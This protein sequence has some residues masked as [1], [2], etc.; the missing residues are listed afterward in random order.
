MVGDNENNGKNGHDENQGKA[1][2]PC[3]GS[4]DSHNSQSLILPPRGDYQTLLS[5]RKSEL[6]Y[7]LTYRF[8]QRFLRRGDRTI[9]QM[10]QAAR[11]GKQNIVEGSKA[12]TT[13]KEMEIKLTNVARASLEELLEDYRDFLKVRD[14]RIWDK[15]STEARYVRKL[16]QGEGVCYDTFREFVDTRP[17]EVVANIAICLVHQANYLLDQQLKRLEKDFLQDG[18][19]RERMTRLRLQERDRQRQEEMSKRKP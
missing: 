5:Y 18:G 17:A 2:E 12:A 7:Q 19:L 8:C 6:V 15:N 4:H 14:L 11:S 9:D 1:A 16:S 13:S 3:H 10:V